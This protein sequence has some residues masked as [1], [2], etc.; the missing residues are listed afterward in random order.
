MTDFL[1]LSLSY[2]LLYKYF[3]LFILVLA[4][5]FILPLPGNAILF[6]SGA[7]SSQG[8]M[9]VWAV[10]FLSV[11]TNVST[12]CFAYYLTYRYG[13]KI[14]KW[15]N[16]KRGPN[17]LKIEK[18]LS[19]FA[20][21]TVFLT[22]LAGPFGPYVNFLSGFLEVSFK[23]FLTFDILGNSSGAVFFVFLGYILGNYWQDFLNNIWFGTV[24]C[25]IVLIIYII[26]KNFL[27]KKKNQGE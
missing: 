6:A 4:G 23:K 26:I 9:N 8:Y 11:L 25:S 13:E 15:L 16:I 7:F 1:S 21:G 20:G 12:D 24:I 2:L 19:N 22:R 3:A 14:F 17:F 10:L 27:I 5:S 18:R